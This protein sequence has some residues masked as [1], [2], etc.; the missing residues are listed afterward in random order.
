MQ[1]QSNTLSNIICDVKHINQRLAQRY[2]CI[3]GVDG[4]RDIK[5][6]KDLLGCIDLHLLSIENWH[7]SLE[8]PHLNNNNSSSISH[9]ALNVI[10]Y[11]AKI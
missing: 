11:I 3:R 8:F 1:Q 7:S 10:S 6:Q 2:D 9:F 5:T 4:F